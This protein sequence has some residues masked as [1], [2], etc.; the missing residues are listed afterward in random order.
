MDTPYDALR[1]LIA[2]RPDLEGFSYIIRNSRMIISYG[3]VQYTLQYNHR[4][5]PEENDWLA[6][7][8]VCD[9]LHLISLRSLDDFRQLRERNLL[10]RHELHRR[11]DPLERNQAQERAQHQERQVRAHERP[12]RPSTS[13]QRP[14]R[15]NIK[16]KI[17]RC[18]V[19]KEWLEGYKGFEVDMGPW[20]PLKDIPFPVENKNNPVVNED[21]PEEIIDWGNLS[22]IRPPNV[23]DWPED[24][25]DNFNNQNNNNNNEVIEPIINNINNN[26]N[27]NVNNNN[28]NNNEISSSNL[29]PSAGQ[30]VD[31]SESPDPWDAAPEPDNFVELVV[32]S[33]NAIEVLSGE[34]DQ[35]V[36]EQVENPVVQAE[37]Q[38]AQIQADPQEILN[39]LPEIDND[40]VEQILGDQVA[41][42]Q[43][44]QATEEEFEGI[45]LATRHVPLFPHLRD[46]LVDIRENQVVN[47][48]RTSYTF[49]ARITLTN[50]IVDVSG[51]SRR[52]ALLL[53]SSVIVQSLRTNAPNQFNHH[54]A[55]RIIRNYFR[56]HFVP[57]E[58]RNFINEH[59]QNQN[60]NQNQNKNR[61]RNQNRNRNRNKNQRRNQSRNRKTQY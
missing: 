61:N 40:L 45:I 60:Q 32:F 55:I 43:P 52:Q 57:N 47:G 9:E 27:N 11:H 35:P 51:S 17:N 53:A 21:W 23:L 13:Q 14:G 46:Y 15:N 44:V 37:Q 25:I 41:E 8:F 50:D 39:A 58:L 36:A 20:V 38:P 12:E 49:S 33:V 16:K 31:A 7:A 1:R 3:G 34:E 29:S 26:V 18:K 6:A 28:N 2:N 56:G 42:Q 48:D 59:N 5:S 30:L 24:A 54:S 19:R 4:L 10:V 22:P